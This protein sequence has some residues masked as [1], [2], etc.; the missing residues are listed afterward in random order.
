MLDVSE[1]H[2]IPV[3]VVQGNEIAVKTQE[4]SPMGV[5]PAAF[6]E[7]IMRLITFSK[8]C[9]VKQKTNSKVF[10][11]FAAIVKEI[12][13]IGKNVLFEAN[14]K[15]A[16]DLPDWTTIVEKNILSIGVTLIVGNSY[17]KSDSPSELGD[18]FQAA[19]QDIEENFSQIKSFISLMEKHRS[20]RIKS[21]YHLRYHPARAQKNIVRSRARS[22]R[23]R[24]RSRFAVAACIS[25]VGGSPGDGSDSADPPRPGLCRAIHSFLKSYRVNKNLTLRRTGL[26]WRL[27]LEWRRAA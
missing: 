18:Y 21:E 6:R 23:S 8:N 20:L 3:R 11:E 1:H 13:S 14:G 2:N 17:R 22:H 26:S 19:A 7:K 9:T 25:G 16:K 12:E 27:P 24:T 15:S 4:E 5:L 10:V